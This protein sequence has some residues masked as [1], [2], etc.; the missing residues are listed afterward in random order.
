MER[1]VESRAATLCCARW[2]NW[3]GGLAA[4]ATRA[5]TRSL[6][7]GARYATTGEPHVP[8]AM[9]SRTCAQEPWGEIVIDLQRNIDARDA[10][11]RSIRDHLGASAPYD[12]VHAEAT[13]A[14]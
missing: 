10:M 11:L 8:R 12:S 9:A 7:Q 1:E 5:A 2:Q 14:S 13:A 4:L 3:K 6:D